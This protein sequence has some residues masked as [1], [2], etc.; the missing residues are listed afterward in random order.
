MAAMPQRNDETIWLYV[1]TEHSGA[2]DRRSP[3]WGPS[4]TPRTANEGLLRFGP[5]RLYPHRGQ[6]LAQTETCA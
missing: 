4:R 2:F 3:R 5:R 6:R 1:R